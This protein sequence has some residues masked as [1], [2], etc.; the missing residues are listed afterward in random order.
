MI[1]FGVYR[2]SALGPSAMPVMRNNLGSP[3]MQRPGGLMDFMK[4]REGMAPNKPTAPS[5]SNGFANFLEMRTGKSLADL[6][7]THAPAASAAPAA[8]GGKAPGGK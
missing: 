8:A 7:S 4:L 3:A 5:G 1:P 2:P 6:I